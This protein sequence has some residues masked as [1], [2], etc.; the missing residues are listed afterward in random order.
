MHRLPLIL[1]LVALAC[2]FLSGAL[3]L[4]IGD[5]KRVLEIRLS[6]SERRGAQLGS[7]LS[8]AKR[9]GEEARARAEADATRAAK[10]ELELARTRERL[11]AAES[12]GAALERNLADTRTV[13]AVYEST[14][15]SLGDEITAL[16]RD[17]EQSRRANAS[18]EAV[19]AYRN[20]I[21]ELER[22][23]ATARNGAALPA[24]AG[25][26]TAVFTNRAGRSTVLSVGP[27]GS[28]VVVNFGS[29]RG[30]QLGHRLNISQG[31]IAVATAVISDVRA[32]FSVAQ[33][34]PESLRGVLQK[35]DSAVLIR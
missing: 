24:A 9:E 5:S 20:T 13:L 8:A 30:A 32:H 21:A 31:T 15:K 27:Q 28:F 16:R 22:Q 2:T 14:A 11:I 35:G 7:D 1:C 3:Y 25:A 18:P 12:Q 19:Q 26:S 17:L 4:R 29:A 10:H 34:Q 33:V 6:E 23:L